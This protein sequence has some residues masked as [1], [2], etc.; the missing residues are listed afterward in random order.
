M[1]IGD[2]WPTWD[3]FK[4][5]ETPF[6][7]PPFT[8]LFQ[9]KEKTMVMKSSDYYPKVANVTI[10]GVPF[11][12]SLFEEPAAPFTRE[13][14]KALVA[15]YP[16]CDRLVFGSVG[17]LKEMRK[18][19]GE[20]FKKYLVWDTR[21]EIEDNNSEPILENQVVLR[22]GNENIA[23]WTKG[24]PLPL[25]VKDLEALSDHIRKEPD[26]GCG[27]DFNK[28]AYELAKNAPITYEDAMILLEK[29]P[30]GCDEIIAAA[31]S[32]GVSPYAIS[33][34]I[35]KFTVKGVS[36]AMVGKQLEKMIR[37]VINP[38]QNIQIEANTAP[39][40]DLDA[41]VDGDMEAPM[42]YPLS[43]YGRPLAEP[44][45]KSP[46]SYQM[47]QPGDQ[48]RRNTISVIQADG[49]EAHMPSPGENYR[50]IETVMRDEKRFF[51]GGIMEE[52]KSG[53][54]WKVH[55]KDEDQAL[56]VTEMGACWAMEMAPKNNLVGRVC[57]WEKLPEYDYHC[58]SKENTVGVAIW[59]GREDAKKLEAWNAT[60]Y[61]HRDP[62]EF[63]TWSV[64]GGWPEKDSE[65]E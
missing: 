17:I 44:A 3:D 8:D 64:E 23:T 7:H 19:I 28:R 40:M 29:H 33:D 43:F 24:D 49:T 45:V 12:D 50:L 36:G 58:P 26:P 54:T 52:L 31:A 10:N 39:S 37:E 11:S 55:L 65:V 34:V 63:N 4:K 32:L 51:C 6:L 18:A 13:E 9:S 42:N 16:G 41:L 2:Y 20:P 25:S 27:T 56:L 62:S 15:A 22:T 38:T 30:V 53:D 48:P 21:I 61:K 1:A 59:P 47:F 5:M 57:T 46:P 35:E 60:E 14:I